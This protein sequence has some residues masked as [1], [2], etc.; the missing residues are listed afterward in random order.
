M[1]AASKDFYGNDQKRHWRG[2]QH[3]RICERIP[4]SR[5]REATVIYL[6]GP[7]D[8]DRQSLLAKG[9][10]DDNLIAVDR[11]ASAVNLVR[12]SGGIA[13]RAELLDVLYQWN[14]MY[15]VDAI[16]ADLFCGLSEASE[17]LGM[18]LSGC[19]ATHGGTVVCMNLMR[20]RD[21][22]GGQMSRILRDHSGVLP[23]GIPP[24]HR[25]YQLW[26]RLLHHEREM[27]GALGRLPF[28]EKSANAFEIHASP[29]F[30]SYRSERGMYF[31]SIVFTAPWAIA[32][33]SESA[34]HRLL[35]K[36]SRQRIS[37]LKIRRLLAAVY[38]VRAA[39][40]KRR[41]R[42]LKPEIRGGYLESVEN[43]T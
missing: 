26:R 10:I 8:R 11:D 13:V 2:W 35:C 14:S 21:G 24:E 32:T 25:G 29:V 15:Q 40:Q 23:P 33:K 20:G 22:I 16:I 30:G 43:V 4:A 36:N 19:D 9:F 41:R 28:W 3:N 37:R 27:W 6:P 12:K 5:R 18:V 17:H 38:A 31:D 39:K 7:E 1:S 34:A 42:Y